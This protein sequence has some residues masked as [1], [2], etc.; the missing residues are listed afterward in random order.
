MS[1]NRA[2]MLFIAAGAVL[3]GVDKILGNR[4]GLGQKFDEGFALMGPMALSMTGI[5][6]LA[7]VISVWLGGA[8]R[9]LLSAVGID[10]AMFGCVL[11]IDMGGYQLAMDLAQDPAIGQFSGIIA[12][13]MFGCTLVCTIPV[14]MSIITEGDRPLFLKGILAGLI[15]LPAGLTVG[16]LLQ[17]MSIGVILYQCIP[18]F[19]LSA[20][21]LLGLSRF[22]HGTIRLFSG[23][24]R[25][26]QI[27]S[28]F[29]LILAA[30]QQ[31]A[32]VTIIP[33]LAS[34]EEALNIVGSIAVVM[35]GS[36]PLAELLRRGLSRPFR[37]IGCKTG[38]ND[39]STT[40]MIVGAVT[41]M[42]ALAM[43]REMDQRGK[44]LCG[45]FLVCGASAFAAHMGF[46]AATEPEL[47]LPLLGGKF[48]GAL[49]G[50]IVSMRMTC[51]DSKQAACFEE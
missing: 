21:V 50:L 10:P 32:G 31:I 17:G 39:S 8:I 14:G 4:F 27:A 16:G 26:I 23:V 2:L 43:V 19:L 36:L 28:T 48:T 51:S 47:I 18:I 44:V 42:P 25:V 35:L 37:W 24:A 3:G 40:G 1:M 45:A 22:P 15:A 30:V 6:C 11:A 34:A 29:G 7:P 9:P 13:S 46:A 41:V 49:V 5:I 12:A 38:L 20:L 33:G